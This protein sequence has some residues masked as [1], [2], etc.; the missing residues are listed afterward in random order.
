MKIKLTNRIKTAAILVFTFLLAHLHA[1][2][3]SP[4]E[5][6][7]ERN[8]KTTGEY[9]VS[10]TVDRISTG[11]LT[12]NAFEITIGPERFKVL[13]PT[14]DGDSVIYSGSTLGYSKRRTNATHH[15]GKSRNDTNTIAEVGSP[16]VLYVRLRA[17]QI[18]E[19]RIANNEDR[20][21]VKF[22]Q[23]AAQAANRPT[24]ETNAIDPMAAVNQEVQIRQLQIEIDK[25]EGELKSGVAG[26]AEVTSYNSTTGVSQGN[27]IYRFSPAEIQEKTKLLEIK[28]A[29]MAA[30]LQ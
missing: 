19:A 21:S 1:A 22:K 2:E 14:S 23:A 5:F 12:K 8:N 15:S 26:K 16:L 25:L 4:E 17:G 9:I 24:G 29:Q 7:Q 11:G 28:K 13:V 3:I 18:S 27:V 20:M 10:G 6:R 30:L